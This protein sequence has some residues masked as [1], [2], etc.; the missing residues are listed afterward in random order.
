MNADDIIRRFEQL[1]GERSVW[2]QHWQEISDYVIPRRGDFIGSPAGLTAGRSGGAKRTEQIFDATAPWALEQL[3]SG[4]H[5]MLSGPA[6][7]WFQLRA[8][9]ERLNQIDSVRRWLEA[10]SLH[11]FN[12]FNKPAANFPAQAHELYLDLAAF[13]TAVMLVE[14]QGG[15]VRYRTRHLGECHIA[16]SA[17]GRVDTLY[18][19]WAWTARQAVQAFGERMPDQ[20]ARMA[21][22]EPQRQF[23]FVHAVF[24]RTERRIGSEL[25]TDKPFASVY[26]SLEPRQVI[27]EGGFDEFPYM[28]PRWSKLTGERYGRSP[29]MT[30]LPDIKMVNSMVKTVIVGAQKMI[31]P[32]LLAPSDGFLNPIRTKPGGINYYDALAARGPDSI[33]PLLT[34][35]QPRLGL[36]LIQSVQQAIVRGFHVDWLTLR[37]GD[38]MTATEIRQRREEQLRLLGP[39]VARSQ[40]EFQDPAIERTLQIE[41]RRSRPFWAAGRDGP[42]PIP[43]RELV[44]AELKIDYITPIGQAQKAVR[45]E[46][47]ARVIEGVERMMAFD[48]ALPAMV[49]AEASVREIADIYAAPMKMLKPPE[50]VAAVRAA[51]AEQQQ[52]QQESA[53]A[54]ET[55]GAA[56][57][58]AQARAAGE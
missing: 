43:P 26:V 30:I 42:L 16:E 53:Q 3:A 19:H 44:E 52:R 27:A 15:T 11:L 49:D 37:Q 20:I 21:E 5:G 7:R 36:D 34:G 9:D 14:D 4:L 23:M 28:V 6:V 56:K 45:V 38:R 13:G 2:E 41:I 18:R 31:D 51:M 46:S 58:L 57:D 35:G 17:S 32:P 12:V 50:A 25:K 8:E 22:T 10:A 39:V 24:P 1:K 48:P 55:A 33:K 47:M 40:T 29:A 54:T